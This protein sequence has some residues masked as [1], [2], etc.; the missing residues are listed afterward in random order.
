MQIRIT[1]QMQINRATE[2]LRRSSTK[3]ALLQQQISSG[4]RLTMPS[5]G[6][7]DF[8]AAR[9][10]LLRVDQFQVYVDNGASATTNLNAGVSAL[11]DAAEILNQATQLTSQGIHGANDAVA[12]EALAQEVD[13]LINRMMRTANSDLGGRSLFAGTATDQ[14][15]FVVTATDANG[16]PVAIAYQGADDRGRVITGPGQTTDTHYVGS[17]IFGDDSSGIFRSLMDLRDTLRNNTLTADAKAQAL[18]ARM[19]DIDSA[20]ASVLGAMG[21]QSV[22]LESLETTQNRLRDMQV[23]LQSRASDLQDTDYAEA[24]ARLGQEQGLYE[25]ALAVISRLFGT[26]LLDYLR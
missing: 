15:P 7:A 17:D 24:I 23:N 6:P 20:R 13:E 8:V 3:Q 22:A 4:I 14:K 26:S 10:A 5:D 11:Q 9:Q 2:A 25:S 21:E 19:T 1:N 18:T 12:Y 16:K